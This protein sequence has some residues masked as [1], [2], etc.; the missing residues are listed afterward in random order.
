MTVH[1]L[2]SLRRKV[3]KMSR[4]LDRRPKKAVS[5][6]LTTVEADMKASIIEHDAVASGELLK[7]FQQR[8]RDKTYS[9][10]FEL[11]NVANHAKYVEFGSGAYHIPNVH[12]QPFKAPDLS[13]RLVAA[14][15]QWAI[16]KPTVVTI[17]NPR[18]FAWNVAKVISGEAADSPG[19]VEPQPFFIP[20]W[21]AGKPVLLNRVRAAVK[22]SV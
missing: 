1:G 19:G 13:L 20:N 14:I 2:K 5:R 15:E 10:E 11:V 22:R 17:G 4:D 8:R 9:T 16:L 21:R 6:T 3:Q 12:T 7:S 18:R